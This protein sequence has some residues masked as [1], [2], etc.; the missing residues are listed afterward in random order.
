MELCT[1]AAGGRGD[2]V[3]EVGEDR[4][5]VLLALHRVVDELDL[6]ALGLGVQLDDPVA[7]DRGR[8]GLA[9]HQLL[10]R[11]LGQLA[12]GVAQRV[13]EGVALRRPHGVPVRRRCAA[14]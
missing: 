3:A 8:R 7:L 1:G 14:R 13:G 4:E 11:V 2:L 10:D 6:A 12:L 9:G 5:D